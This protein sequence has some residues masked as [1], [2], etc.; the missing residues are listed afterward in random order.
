MTNIFYESFEGLYWCLSVIQSYWKRAEGMGGS[1]S[2]SFI[3]YENLGTWLTVRESQCLRISH[4][5][6][7]NNKITQ[8]IFTHLSE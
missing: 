6:N 1:S 3:N 5:K 7:G 8:L 4:F 2:W